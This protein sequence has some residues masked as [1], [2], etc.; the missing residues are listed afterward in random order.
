M[1]YLSLRKVLGK[2]SGS[3]CEIRSPSH[4]E[5][6]GLNEG[7]LVFIH[8]CG[9]WLQGNPSEDRTVVAF[10]SPLFRLKKPSVPRHLKLGQLEGG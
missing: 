2:E 5:S 3:A 10:T 4:R 8:K 1:T 6:R 7:P 9:L